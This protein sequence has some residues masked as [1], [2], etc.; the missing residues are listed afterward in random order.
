MKYN[1]LH[2]FTISFFTDVLLQGTIKSRKLKNI[3]IISFAHK[4]LSEKIYIFFTKIIAA[5]C[6]CYLCV[7]R[8]SRNKKFTITNV[9]IL[10]LHCHLYFYY[11]TSFTMFVLYLFSW[12]ESL[13][14]LSLSVISLFWLGYDIWLASAVLLILWSLSPSSCWSLTILSLTLSELWCINLSHNSGNLSRNAS[15]S[16]LCYQPKELRWQISYYASF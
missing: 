4:H 6:N 7:Q 9:V 1:K 5:S 15:F 14:L 10:S 8:E 12:F 3:F 11:T 2:V 13:S 16:S